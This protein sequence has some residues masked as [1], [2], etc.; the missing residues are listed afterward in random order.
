MEKIDF[1]PLG[2]VITAQGGLRKLIIVGRALTVRDG[3]ETYYFDYASVPY[4]MGVT[5]EEMVYLNHDAVDMVL[6][7]GYDDDDNKIIT[8]MIN[9]Y[10]K[11]HP[12]V[13]RKV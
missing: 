11:T 5:G 2:S 8:G 13:K 10:L 7:V 9:D 3:E 1:L 12:N 4:P 6:F